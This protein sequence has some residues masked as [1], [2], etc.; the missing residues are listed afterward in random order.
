MAPASRSRV[1]TGAVRVAGRCV[2]SQ[3]GL[4]KQAVAPRTANTSLAAKVSPASGRAEVAPASRT[5]V[6]HADGARGGSRCARSGRLRQCPP[7]WKGSVSA[8]GG[9]LRR[10]TPD[11]ATSASTY[12]SMTSA[13]VGRGTPIAGNTNCSEVAAPNSKQAPITPAERQPPEDHRRHG[14][15]ACPVGHAFR[16]RADG[17]YRHEH[18][19]QARAARGVEHGQEAD[20]LDGE[21][22]LIGGARVLADGAHGEAER[23]LGHQ[24]PGDQ[25]DRERGVDQPGLLEQRRSDKRHTRQQRHRHRAERRDL[26][27]RQAAEDLSVQERRRAEREDVEADAHDELVGAHA[28]A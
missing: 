26:L 12:G 27:A 6:V 24:P 17:R 22:R 19:G 4:P 14:Q 15:I 18:P 13:A 20:A 28:H 1:T 5:L 16:E 9:R 2:A 7:R 21:A 11:T 3:V 23:R 10:M 8:A 25:D